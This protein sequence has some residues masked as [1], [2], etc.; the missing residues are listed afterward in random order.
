VHALVVTCARTLTC[1]SCQQQAIKLRSF[2]S[3][4]KES[5]ASSST[6]EHRRR[7]SIGNME[8][9]ILDAI[10]DAGDALGCVS[11][12]TF[13]R[14]RDGDDVL[15]RSLSSAHA[16]FRCVSIS[17]SLSLIRHFKVLIASKE[18]DSLEKDL[19]TLGLE[20]L[21]G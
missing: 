1:G 15:E 9:R 13:D 20:L 8:V 3:D 21:R 18:M 19:A 2:R 12:D 5:L 7:G 11:L 10:I 4:N 14:T 17:L 16:C 6:A